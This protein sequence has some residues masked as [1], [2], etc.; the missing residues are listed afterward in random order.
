MVAKAL[1]EL[2]RAV[3]SLAYCCLKTEP[4][5]SRIRLAKISWLGMTRLPCGITSAMTLPSGDWAEAAPADSII[6]A[7]AIQ[8]PARRSVRFIGSAPPRSPV[9]TNAQSFGYFGVRR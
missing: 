4:G 2:S 9:E 6:A 3:S 8:H 7:A 5:L 1:V